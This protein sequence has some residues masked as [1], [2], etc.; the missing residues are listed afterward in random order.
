MMYGGC[1]TAF[2]MRLKTLS[3]LSK[4]AWSSSEKCLRFSLVVG[5]AASDGRSGPDMMGA[6]TGDADGAGSV[7]GL[8]QAV[9]VIV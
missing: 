2:F 1:V 5:T 4:S 9:A 3:S 7:D 6:R 8:S